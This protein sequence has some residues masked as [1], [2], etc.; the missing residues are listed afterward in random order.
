MDCQHPQSWRKPT[1]G[2]RGLTEHSYLHYRLWGWDSGREETSIRVRGLSA[3][4]REK[5]C[6]W[7]QTEGRGGTPGRQV[8]GFRIS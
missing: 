1:G 6:G 5:G 8:N 2:S 4:F 7:A 3:V